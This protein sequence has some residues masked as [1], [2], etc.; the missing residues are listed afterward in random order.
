[1]A[2]PTTPIDVDQYVAISGALDSIDTL[3]VV[4]LSPSLDEARCKRII[5]LTNQIRTILDQPTPP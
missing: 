3:A 1:M 4:G 5:E 2:T